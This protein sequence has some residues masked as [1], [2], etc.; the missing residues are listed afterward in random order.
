[1]SAPVASDT[2][3]PLRASSEISVLGGRAEPGG[4]EKGTELVAVQ[5][6]GLR[7]VVQPRPADVSRR[8]V[9]ENLFLDRVLI[10]PGDGAQPPGDGGAGPPAG[11]QFASEGLDIR[12]ADGEQGK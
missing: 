4:D 8:G 10:E 3:S 1:M 9:V 12:T 2:R 5:S 6:G 7:L 11:L